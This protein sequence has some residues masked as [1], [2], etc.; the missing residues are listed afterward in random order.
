[1]FE[2]KLLPDSIDTGKINALRYVNSYGTDFGFINGPFSFQ[3]EFV[4]SK[5]KRTVYPTSLFYKGYYALVA[6]TLSGERRGYDPKYN[7]FFN[8][9]PANDFS[10]KDGNYGAW[11]VAMRYNVID[12]NSSY[13]YTDSKGIIYTGGKMKNLSTSL[14]WYLSK[15][16]SIMF[17]YIYGKTDSKAVV[18]NDK[19]NIFLIRTNLY[20]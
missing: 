8:L 16:M 4:G 19:A 18:P 20:F 14:N 10:I 9:T 17:T 3:A 6:Y 5:I 7:K 2:T 13:T 1:M 12:L 15:N 11:E